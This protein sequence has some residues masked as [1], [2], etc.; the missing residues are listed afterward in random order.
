MNFGSIGDLYKIRFDSD[1]S[2][3]NPSWFLNKVELKDMDTGEEF[4][5]FCE[6]W[7]GRNP[8]GK[9][10]ATVQNFREIPVVRVGIEPLPGASELTFLVMNTT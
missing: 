3:R 8:D 6:R 5:L 4:L 10:K 9:E 2:G 7:L 1:E